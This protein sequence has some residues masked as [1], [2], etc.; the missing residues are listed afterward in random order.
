MSA[1]LTRRHFVLASAAAGGAL[2]LG[3]TTQ[4]VRRAG[5][6]RDGADLNAFVRIDSDGIVTVVL[7]KVEM[8]QGTYTS[9]PMLVAEELEVELGAIRVEPAPPNPAVYGFPVDANVYGFAVDPAQHGFARDQ[10]TG[11][12][13]SIIQCWQPLRQAGAT[14]RV[15][16]IAAA[17]QRWDVS[18]ASCRAAGG[19]VIHD[20]S[21]RRLGYGALAQAAARLPVPEPPPLKAPKDFRLIGRATP[22]R[23]TPA[24]VNGSAVFGIDV[25]PPQARVALIAIAPVEGGR[26]IEPLAS[27]AALAVPGV[28]QIVNE[29]DVVAVVADDTWTAMKGM[30]ALAP[31]WDDGANGAV[32]QAGLVAELEAAVHEDGVVAAHSGDPAAAAARCHAAARGVISPAVPR[33]RDPRTDELHARMASGRVRDLDR[34]AG[35][36]SRG[37]EACSA[38]PQARADPAA[39][40]P[41]RW[42]LW[43]ATRGRRHRHRRAHRTPRHGTGAGAVESRA[44]YPARPLPAV[45]RRSA[46]RRVG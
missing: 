11:T 3:I 28:R 43:T 19:A 44:G 21:G 23:D 14:A 5:H 31:R 45:L 25:R 35:A 12:S 18:P 46:E 37:R 30:K 32:Q 29:G 33:A 17:A 41:D 24:K 10:S 9:L 27:A 6:P 26:V 2:V 4:R 42:R 16:L 20:S 13:L 1:A 22:R 38:G 7:P 34:H 39:Q 40:P 8:G 36:G 15:M